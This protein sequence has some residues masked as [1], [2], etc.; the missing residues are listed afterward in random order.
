MPMMMS[1]IAKA[2]KNPLESRVIT[3]MRYLG[4]ILLIPLVVLLIA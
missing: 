4:L 3:K 1:L 2:R